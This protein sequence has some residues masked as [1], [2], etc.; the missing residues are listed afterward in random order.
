MRFRDFL[1][2]TT[3]ENDDIEEVSVLLPATILSSCSIVLESI[4]QQS[5]KS[6]WVYRV[7]PEDP[8]L[9]Q[10]RHV[11]IAKEKHKNAKNMQASWNEN[12]T[13]HDKK[14][15]NDSVGKTKFVRQLARDVLN[16]PSTV[17]L[18]SAG[19]R[20]ITIAS[21]SVTFSEDRKEAYIRFFVQA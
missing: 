4:W 6:G 14:S 9:P 2:N 18:E 19:S 3:D 12:G 15:F 8:A 17:C 5:T 1:Q 21:D 7:D 16:I 20:N 11:H 13:R 10:Q